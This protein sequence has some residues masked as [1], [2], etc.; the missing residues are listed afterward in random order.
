MIKFSKKERE[1][2]HRIQLLSS[3]PYPVVEKVFKSLLIEFL[4]KY[5]DKEPATIPLFGDISFNFLGDKVTSKGR[6][7]EIDIDFMPHDFLLK[8]IGQVEDGEKSEIEKYLQEM[9][10][11]SLLEL[12]K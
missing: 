10:D 6:K 11:K 3:I 5:L 9:I 1:V 4:I 12:M 2:I 8:N 7:A